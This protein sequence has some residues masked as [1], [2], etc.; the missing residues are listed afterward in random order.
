[1]AAPKNAMQPVEKAVEEL[2][3]YIQ[4]RKDAIVGVLPNQDDRDV[5]MRLIRSAISRRPKL[6]QCDRFSLLCAIVES[7]TLGLKIETGLGHGWILPFKNR[8]NNTTDA[9]LIIGYQGYLELC[10]RSGK[11]KAV[12]AEIVHKNDVFKE[13][14]GTD[15]CIVHERNH[16]KPGEMIGAYAV[17]ELTTGGKVF[18]YLPKSEVM[19]HKDAS[20]AKDS[21]E[22][23]WNDKRW[24][25]DM[26]RK[27]AI[28]V[29]QKYIPKSVDMQTADS[30]ETDASLGRPQAF[31]LVEEI[32]R[33]QMPLLGIDQGEREDVRSRVAGK[34]P[35]KKEA[36]PP[37]KAPAP[38]QAEDT[39]PPEPPPTAGDGAP[40]PP[41]DA[42]PVPDG[43]ELFDTP[44]DPST[45]PPAKTKGSA[46][47]EPPPQTS[48]LLLA[49]QEENIQL[50]ELGGL[51]ELEEDDKFFTR[52][53]VQ[54][55]T[56]R[57]VGMKQINAVSFSDEE[58]DKYNWQFTK[59]G[60]KPSWIG[61][62]LVVDVIGRRK[63][64]FRNQPQF[65]IDDWEPAEKR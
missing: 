7:T 62:G 26:W 6:T 2:H 31:A 42:G 53:V 15:P 47:H 23:P 49:A 8:R 45:E 46:P 27:T 64:S 60:S 10:Y 13:V 57:Q 14:I 16:E 41:A 35:P 18:R 22:S 48:R 11:V 43:G 5:M 20:P 65:V 39:P 38:K 50:I 37:A 21:P 56:H 58:G 9:V 55:H 28:R 61:D 52:A 17:M 19:T 54:T 36:K 30:L 32:Q 40:D 3:Q 1:M 25:P 4:D 24:E 63:G 12:W 33:R 51:G 44:P 34:T 59:W 29:L